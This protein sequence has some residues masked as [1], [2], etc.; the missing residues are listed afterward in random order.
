MQGC[1]LSNIVPQNAP[2]WQR[3][4]WK[5]ELTVEEAERMFSGPREVGALA[6]Q[7]IK[8]LQ[9]Y[10]VDVS[11]EILVREFEK[12]GFEFS[13]DFYFG[14]PEDND[15]RQSFLAEMRESALSILRARDQNKTDKIFKILNEIQ[16][17]KE[18][19]DK[20]LKALR[21]ARLQSP[22]ACDELEYLRRYKA[23]YF[24][25]VAHYYLRKAMAKQRRLS[26]RA[27][28]ARRHFLNSFNARTR[29]PRSA[30][31]ASFSMAAASP[32]GGG[33]SSGESDQGDPPGPHLP[34]P[35]LTPLSNNKHDQEPSRPWLGLGSFRMERGRSAW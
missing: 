33:D 7:R 17:P 6:M 9:R 18:F 14:L 15:I 10:G 22:Q 3:L 11:V 13:E 12:N 32:G 1:D 27:P 24:H 29:A 19:R 2:E 23:I 31:R 26:S 34:C 16:A 20:I 30:R 35:F 25:E 21:T 4:A 5:R 8:A 28:L